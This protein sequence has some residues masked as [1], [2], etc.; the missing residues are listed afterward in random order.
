MNFVDRVI[1]TF[2]PQAGLK[3]E[4]ARL[5]LETLSAARQRINNRYDGATSGH[6]A[7]GWNVVGSDANA[8]VMQGAAR[9]RNAARD[10]VRN[11]AYAKRGVSAIVGNT[12]GQ[13]IIPTA[14]VTDKKAKKPLEEVLREHF[15]TPACHVQ[16]QTNLYGIQALALKAAVTDG[17]SLV[18]IRL[19]D[20]RAKL[21][22]P[23]Q[24]EVLEADFLNTMV[25]GTLENKNRAVQGIEYDLSGRPI[26]Y[27]L[28]KEHPGGRGFAVKWESE[29][30]PAELICHVYDIER[31][32]MARGA[33]WFA[34]VILR[35]RDFH[36]YNEAQLIRQKIAACF[37]AFV[38][39]SAP[40]M[41]AAPDANGQTPG[42]N[43]LEQLEPGI[44]E[45][46]MP[47]DT[48]SF[49]SP[50]A[51]TDLKDYASV[52]L[53]EIAAGL[54]VSHEVLSGDYSQVNFTSGRMGWIEFNRS[55]LGWREHM[56]APQ[57]L[58]KIGE[59]FLQY[60]RINRA[61]RGDAKLKWTAPRREVISPR[62]E[63]PFAIEAIKAG[64]ISRSEW[65]LEHGRD[66][67]EVDEEI[68][69]DNKR[70]QSLGLTLS[71]NAGLELA[72][73][74]AANENR[75]DAE[76]GD[77]SG[78]D[79]DKPEEDDEGQDKRPAQLN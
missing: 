43:Y 14:V 40:D 64:L 44:I 46:L 19:R 6:R 34:P 53:H 69:E 51:V 55:C 31:P 56:I 79:G 45:T 35:M 60:A 33:S 12:V 59:V 50:P 66:P 16:G 7:G 11:N 48:V 9:L 36:S 13:G 72:M 63:I 77:K 2:A 18:R 17:E 62:D 73:K 5:R 76:G 61:A 75:E 30:V 25:D 78:E 42:G 58:S 23:F 38:T 71:S 67:E 1:S 37:A 15:D 49:A 10:L 4:L 27:H 29:R 70:A 28:F 3:R 20:S 74:Q 47:G 21:P 8:E 54:N 65:I 24:L 52:T 32:G 39:K 41:N 26:A 68:S 57:L 22:L